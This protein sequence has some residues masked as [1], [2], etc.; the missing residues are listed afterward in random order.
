MTQR[1]KIIIGAAALCGVIAF[2]AP[3]YLEVRECRSVAIEYQML[4]VQTKALFEA[5]LNIRA[6]EGYAEM[7]A[8]REK[9]KNYCK[10]SNYDYAI[11]GNIDGIGMKAY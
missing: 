10:G 6:I 1:L 8:M 11:L 2:N 4:K 5:N 3:S 7:E 9:M